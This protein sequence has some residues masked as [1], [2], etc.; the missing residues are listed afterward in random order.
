MTSKFNKP[1]NWVNGMAKNL[2]V[3]LITGY[4]SITKEFII[5]DPWLYS[6]GTFEFKVKVNEISSIYN[7]IGKKSIIVR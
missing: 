3:L 1:T 6:N 7:E 2:H 5:T 4:N